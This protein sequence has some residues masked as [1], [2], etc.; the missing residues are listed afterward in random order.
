MP[1][2]TF[3]SY[4]SCKKGKLSKNKNKKLDLLIDSIP[5]LKESILQFLFQH[6]TNLTAPDN[7]FISIA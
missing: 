5:F 1:V 6:S 3:P 7:T 4:F 2:W